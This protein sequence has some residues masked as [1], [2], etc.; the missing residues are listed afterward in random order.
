MGTLYVRDGEA[1]KYSPSVLKCLVTAA[2]S[3]KKVE[4]KA[5]KTEDGVDFKFETENMVEITDPTSVCWCLSENNDDLGKTCQILQWL[6]YAQSDVTPYLLGYLHH[7]QA[8][9][10]T[11]DVSFQQKSRL[12]KLQKSLEMLN[13]LIKSRTFLV[14]DRLT[15]AD[16]ILAVDLI[17]V[18]TVSIDGKILEK[19]GD[20]NLTHLRRWFYTIVNQESFKSVVANISDLSLDIVTSSKKE[21]PAKNMAQPEPLKILCLHGYRQNVAMFKEKLGAFRK[22]VRKKVSLHYIEA[23]HLVPNEEAVEQR[24]WW[25]SGEDDY[26]KA[27]HVSDCDKGFN[28][29]LDLIKN[30]IAEDGPFDG[31]F[32]FSQGAA[33]AVMLELLQARGGR[34]ADGLDFKFAMVVAPFK[35]RSSR[36]SYL[37]D[38]KL[39]GKIEIPTLI[40]IGDT[41]QV[42][43]LS[44]SNELLPYFKNATVL[45][46][47]GGHFVPATGKQKSDYLDFL[48][49]MRETI[50]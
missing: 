44:M 22:I 40:V 37:Y 19:L 5:V 13:D 34:E 24:G 48:A 21:Q 9:N 29:S 30:F 35:S 26:F 39:L 50:K 32:A 1:A 31:L 46:H 3:D 36:H 38:E 12:A 17:S 28:E 27:T 33:L 8:K 18:F 16:I 25:F 42:I 11:R 41:D 14:S 6:N 23:P 15:L 49:K 45:R 10:P 7:C 20:K 43:E 47:P 2:F 4:L